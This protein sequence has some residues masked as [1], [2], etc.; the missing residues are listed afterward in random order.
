MPRYDIRNG[1]DGGLY[2]FA[3]DTHGAVK[4]GYRGTKF[5]NP[6]T[7]A[8]GVARS[9][10][11]TRWT[12]ES[13]RQ[14][15]LTSARVIKDFV[16]EFLPELMSCPMKSRL[17]WYT[18]SFDNHFVIDFVPG[19][20][21]LMV[22]TGGSGHGF[23]FLPTLGAHVV[24]RIEGKENEYLSLWK[25]RSL[26]EDIKPYNSVMEGNKSERSWHNQILTVEDSLARQQSRL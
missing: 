19:V 14:L 11:M 12:R 2:G 3:R 17:C 21:G 15:P 18:D 5:T 8:D 16:Q 1:K 9:V 13:T 26:G 22:A 6:Q 24:D 23:K 7:Q 10:P 20:S 25:W 4:I